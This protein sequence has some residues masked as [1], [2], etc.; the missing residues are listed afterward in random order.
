[1]LPLANSTSKRFFA[2]A[3]GLMSYGP[4]YL[5]QFRRSAGYVD[6]IIKGEKPARSACHMPRH[7]RLRDVHKIANASQSAL[8]QINQ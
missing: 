5:D 4:E 6:R 1:L 3:G 7:P 8:M 2:A